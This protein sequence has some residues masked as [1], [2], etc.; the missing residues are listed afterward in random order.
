MSAESDLYTILSG[1]AAL[2]ALVST[3]IYPDAIPEDKPYPAVVFV[4]AGTEPIGT[5]HGTTHGEFASMRIEC[6]GK[7]RESADAV[8]AAVNAALVAA[9][10][11]PTGRAGGFDPEAGLFATTIEVTLLAL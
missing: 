11:V 4:R 9:K 10:E 5:I 6:W 2:T 3:R 8:A 7:N 1:H